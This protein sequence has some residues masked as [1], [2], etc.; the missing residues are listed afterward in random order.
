[1]MVMIIEELLYARN[2][3]KS[4][5]CLMSFES[6][7]DTLRSVLLLLSPFFFFTNE[8]KSW[9]VFSTQGHTFV[10]IWKQNSIGS[11]SS[12]HRTVSMQ[13]NSYPAQNKI[14]TIDF[15]YRKIGNRLSF[16]WVVRIKFSSFVCPN[17]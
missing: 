13:N 1:M 7:K 6:Y 9:R 8:G 2:Y 10:M 3:A 16:I 12:L 17:R 5:T 14:I 15:L 4:S 11:H